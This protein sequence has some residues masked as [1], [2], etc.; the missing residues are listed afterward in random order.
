MTDGCQLPCDADCEIGPV[1]CWN[2]HRPSHKPDWH[3][4]A[5]CDVALTWS[6]ACPCGWASGPFPD[7]G[8]VSDAVSGHRLHDCPG[9]T[10]TGEV[11]F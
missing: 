8:G 7:R 3:D 2:Y 9:R 11:M 5:E 4:P 6:A 1:H 10:I